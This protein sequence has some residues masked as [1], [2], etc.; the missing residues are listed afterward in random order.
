MSGRSGTPNWSRT[1]QP[2]AFVPAADSTE[3]GIGWLWTIRRANEE[4]SIRV[5]ITGG[6]F[7]VTDLP[8]KAQNAIRSR[9]ATAVDAYLHEDEPPT[10][11]IVS[12]A[13][14][15]PQGDPS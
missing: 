3:T 12:T 15:H 13:G 7:R 9:G 10:H 6:P 14:V 11:I 5:E 2:V 8:A 4:R 1:A